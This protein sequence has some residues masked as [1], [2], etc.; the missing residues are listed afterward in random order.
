MPFLDATDR[1]RPRSRPRRR[2]LVTL[3]VAVVLATAA[4]AAPAIAADPDAIRSRRRVTAMRVS[5]PIVVD[6]HLDEAAWHDAEPAAGFV[7]QQPD[8]G[9]ASSQPSD[10]RFLYDDATL[11]VGGTFL[12]DSPGDPIVDTLKRDVATRDGDVVAIALDTFLDGRNAFTFATNPGGAVSDGQSHDDGRQHNTDWNGVWAVRTGRVAGGWTMEMAIPFRSLRFPQ[13]DRQRWGLN[14]VRVLPR[15]KEI[16][17]W[18]PVPRQFTE[19]KVSHA[20]LLEGIDRVRAGRSLRVK[21]ALVGGVRDGHGH[22]DAGLDVKYGW[23]DLT[24][25]LTLR[26]DYSQVE[27]DEEQI[28][29]TRISPVLPEK[30]EFF[31]ENQGAF[32]VGDQ[33]GSNGSRDLLPFLSRRIGLVDG[34]PV[35][36]HV[37]ARVSGRQGGFGVGALAVTTALPDGEPGQQQ[38]IAARATRDLGRRHR[39]GAVYLARESPLGTT[40]A[41]GLDAHLGFGGSVLVDA[42]ALRSD[43]STPVEGRPWALRGGLQVD[44]RRQTTR[45]AYTNIGA[46]YRNELGY[47]ARENAGTLTWEHEWVFR[48][49]APERWLR[50]ITIGGEGE[51]VDDSQHRLPISRLTRQDTSLEFADGGRAGVDLDRNVEHL[52]EPFTIARDVTL[53]P[54]RYP[55]DRLTASYRSDRT[56]RLSGTIGVTAG[57]FWSGEMAGTSIAARLR[58]SARG[59]VSG[60]LDRHHAVLP[61]GR[62][63][64]M[65]AKVRVDWSFSTRAALNALLQYNSARRAWLTNAR[66]SLMHRP[67]SDVFVVYTE[68]RP[69]GSPAVRSVALKYTHLLSF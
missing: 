38:F 21:P 8:E 18:S 49:R 15:R 54:G 12:D 22:R 50:G 67:L 13:Q 58:L 43:A 27:A 55:F 60:T 31:L 52:V 26:A 30:R 34:T 39:L 14:I 16:A 45:A 1:F 28:N 35:P 68:T 66:L 6:G 3:V 42:V 4:T 69:D 47:V 2:P 25:D 63:D 62:F 36:V 10:V 32:T 23:R 17:V 44:T 59:A 9:A 53:A 24:W 5:V 48:P 51:H 33:T 11:Y 46:G 64:T 29:L 37:G 56:R 65:L 20:G 61:E 57:D 19:R 7:Q 40:R 41:A